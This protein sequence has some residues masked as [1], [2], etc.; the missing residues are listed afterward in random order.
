MTGSTAPVDNFLRNAWEPIA[1]PRWA[2]TLK[3][4][5]FAA[6]GFSAFFSVIQ[7]LDLAT[8]DGYIYIWAA[9]M[10]FGAVIGAIGSFRPKWGF[11]EAI[12]AAIVFSFLIVLTVLMFARAAIPIGF[13]LL[14][15]T[16][17]P[18]VRAGFL[19]IRI[20]LA[21]IYRESWKL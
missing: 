5:L 11:I 10:S 19:G 12:G 4:V 3:Y 21:M 2:I 16:I 13:L 1:V 6:C 7:T 9:C 14:I 18:G 20:A 17:I 15:I 8:P